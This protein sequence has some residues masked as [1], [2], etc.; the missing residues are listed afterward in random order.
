MAYQRKRT[1]R[2][3]PKSRFSKRWYIDASIPKSMPFI[4]GTTL[5]AGSG[6]LT[7]RSLAAAVKNAARMT[8]ANKNKM[9]IAF[10]NL[11]QGTYYTFNP[12]G[13]IPIGTGETAR[14]GADIYVDH[15]SIKAIVHSNPTL[16]GAKQDLPVHFRVMWVRSTQAVASGSDTFISGLGAS[17]LNVESTTE[18]ILAHLDKDKVTV[19]SDNYYT[20]PSPQVTGKANSLTLDLSCPLKGF[21][22]KYQTATSSFSATNKNI[23]CVIVPYI[24]GGTTGTDIVM[25]LYSQSW[26]QF[27]DSR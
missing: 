21:P 20:I 19:L 18:P 4:G 25:T 26:V 22:F 12:L 14:I 23:Y 11:V 10:E 27:S 8:D 24:V 2:S 15:I 16:P 1:Y 5:R 13:N 6:T 3:K 17:S 7:K 9:A